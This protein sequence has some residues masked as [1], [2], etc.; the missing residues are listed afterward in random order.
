[1]EAAPPRLVER[2]ADGAA[3]RADTLEN[4]RLSTIVPLLM[5]SQTRLER[6]LLREQETVGAR[7]AERLEQETLGSHPNL[8]VV[9]TAARRQ[10][11]EQ[12]RERAQ[13]NARP[14]RTARPGKPLKR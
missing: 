4:V 11:Q 6:R 9:V 5:R 14:R 8:E 1:M 12:E 7:R 2:G 3:T 13:A 10:Q